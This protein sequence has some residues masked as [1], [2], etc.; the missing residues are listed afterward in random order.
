MKGFPSGFSRIIWKNFRLLFV[1]LLIPLLLFNGIY[2]WH[3]VQTR[4][5]E[6]E[7]ENQHTFENCLNYLDDLW[8]STTTLGQSL[9]NSQDTLA[10]LRIDRTKLSNQSIQR[11][12]RLRR[13][14]NAM[15]LCNETVQSVALC[16]DNSYYIN[17]S[18]AF[19]SLRP[20]PFA[21]GYGSASLNQTLEEL[22]AQPEDA[23][24]S[25]NHS[26]SLFSY[27][28]QIDSEGTRACLLVLNSAQ[29]RNR[30]DSYL[31]DAQAVV[32]YSRTGEA[33]FSFGNQTCVGSTGGIIRLCENSVHGIETCSDVSGWRIS[34][35]SREDR[36][37]SA[38]RS[39]VNQFMLLTLLILAL[40][41]A[42]CYFIALTV[43]RPY[44]AIASLLRRPMQNANDL[45]RQE[46]EDV[47]DLG[48]I[49]DL[50]FR[51]K[52]QLYAAQSEL[53]SQEKLLKDARV[54]A[55]QAQINPHFLYN[56]LESINW[57]VLMLP[58]DRSVE[59]SEM[60]C[61]LSTLMRLSLENNRTLIP[62]REEIAHARIYLKI[63]QRRFPNKFQM[64]WDVPDEL[65]DAL[66]IPLTLHPLLENAL[67]HGIKKMHG[68]GRVCV[69]C[70][71]EQTRLVVSVEDNGPGF[72]PEALN[73]VRAR[74][75]QSTL[76]TSDHVGLFNANQRIRL[77]F[78][79][80]YGVSI[81]SEAFVRTCVRMT[82]PLNP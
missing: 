76:R 27:I 8:N 52:Y 35:I 9:I 60:I 47:D 46:Y 37:Q 13:L 62:L 64:E 16:L 23:L 50:I 32:V 20:D 28:R 66:V 73:V 17:Q 81:D 5:A 30:L 56:T 63:Q 6:L 71:A 78:D 75:S 38:I 24:W 57:K 44:S 79:G 72:S 18:G 2:Q 65:L 49:R 11:L 39:A 22:A 15:L 41:G 14:M 31:S 48:I 26:N 29:L 53:E 69:R 3:S 7:R 43:C 61:D 10:L 68:Q 34:F 59:I 12:D 4:K 33:L 36:F 80:D 58:S 54:M 19:V 82:L 40:C 25:N 74:L 42:L 1:C 45:Y 67:G 51:S 21:N 77:T 55:L 70:A